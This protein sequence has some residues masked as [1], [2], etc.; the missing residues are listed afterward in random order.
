M[1][2]TTP[3]FFPITGELQTKYFYTRIP[4][5]VI[6]WLEHTSY[7]IRIVYFEQNCIL[8]AKILVFFYPWT[9][10]MQNINFR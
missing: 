8:D 4:E 10:K 9:L 7:E 5:G 2:I 3:T 6:V 1:F